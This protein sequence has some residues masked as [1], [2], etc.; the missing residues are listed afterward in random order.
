MKQIVSI[1]ERRDRTVEDLQEITESDKKFDDIC[2]KGDWTNLPQKCG[3]NIEVWDQTVG[4]PTC[5]MNLWHLPDSDKWPEW[6]KAN[7]PSPDHWE[8]WEKNTESDPYEPYDRLF[9]LIHPFQFE[10]CHDHG[11]EDAGPRK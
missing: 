10:D 1:A 4:C 3:G 5:G 8:R 11:D 9:T 2:W 6:D 7:A